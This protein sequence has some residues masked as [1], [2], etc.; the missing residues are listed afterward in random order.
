MLGGVFGNG[1]FKD[2][3][4]SEVSIGVGKSSDGKEAAFGMRTL[5]VVVGVSSASWG[6]SSFSPL[7][8]SKVAAALDC[9]KGT[10]PTCISFLT[11]TPF[12]ASLLILST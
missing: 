10:Y 9:T 6:F 2:F 8:L 11:F 3:H 12:S 1:E 7:P 4:W 5:G